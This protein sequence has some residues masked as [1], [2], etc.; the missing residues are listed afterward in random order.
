MREPESHKKL[1]VEELGYRY[2]DD[3]TE[4]LGRM[5]EVARQKRGI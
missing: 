4:C 5:I 3:W 1:C 2:L